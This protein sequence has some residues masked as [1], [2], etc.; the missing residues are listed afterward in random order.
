M[1]SEAW[2][3]AGGDVDEFWVRLEKQHP[4]AAEA[5]KDE[6][7]V[8]MIIEVAREERAPG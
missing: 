8:P 6:V 1:I 4:E 5:L 2:L 3:A 7:L